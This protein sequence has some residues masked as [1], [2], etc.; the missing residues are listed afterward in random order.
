MEERRGEAFA[1]D[2]LL[3]VEWDAHLMRF[4]SIRL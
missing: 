2:V 1:N 3:E 4:S